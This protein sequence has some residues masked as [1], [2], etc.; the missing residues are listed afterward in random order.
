MNDWDTLYRLGMTCGRAV[1][2]LPDEDRDVLTA[3]F[4]AQRD[5]LRGIGV[6]SGWHAGAL[7]VLQADLRVPDVKGG[8]R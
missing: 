1:A 8:V 5:Q 2:E 4:A 6:Q 7:D 3:L